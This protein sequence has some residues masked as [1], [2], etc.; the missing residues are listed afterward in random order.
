ME[1]PGEVKIKSN[2]KEKKLE[3]DYGVSN[4][5]AEKLNRDY[6][7]GTE[8]KY[9]IQKEYL[10]TFKELLKVKRALKLIKG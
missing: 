7:F 4:K 5:V 9:E 1:F 10:H 6:Y 2:G 3:V 8:L